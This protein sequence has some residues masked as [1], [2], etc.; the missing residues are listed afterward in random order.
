MRLVS[1]HD[2]D[3][4]GSILG[5]PVRRV[6]DPTSSPGAA[7][8]STTCGSTAP[9]TRS[10]CAARFAH[11]RI[12][13]IDTGEAEASPGV[14]AVHTA[15]TLGRRPGAVVRRSSTRPASGPR[16]PVDAVRYVGDPVALVVAET[17]AQAVDAAELVDVDYDELRRGRRHGGGARRRRPAAVPRARQQ[18][19]RGRCAHP[20]DAATPSPTPTSWSGRGSRTSAIAIA[21]IEGNAILVDPRRRA[22]GLLTA[23]SPPSTRTW[24]ATC[25][26]STPGS[27]SPTSR[28]W[29]P[30]VGGAFGGKAGHRL[31]PRRDRRRG[32]PPR[33]PGRLDRDPQRGDALDARPRPGAVRRARAAPRRQHRRAPGPRRSA[34]AAP[35]PASAASL[36]VGPTHIMAQ[37]PYEI[38]QIDYAAI[39]ATDQH[40][41]QRRLPRCRAPGGDGDARAADRPR[42]RRARASRRRRSGVAT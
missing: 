31:R 12:T 34:T 2:P 40:R 16:S 18:R 8:T 19:R 42:R 23:Y 9:P 10:S 7:P 30:H 17:R 22:T 13:R 1:D 37:G 25:W 28:S 38:P 21:P 24:R 3:A 41:T 5:N 14:L 4:S 36:A 35:T 6:E 32:P 15:E 39:A 26:R 11:A 27:T 20:D 33:P 29:S